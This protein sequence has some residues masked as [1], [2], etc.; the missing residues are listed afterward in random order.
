MGGK[1]NWR[2]SGEGYISSTEGANTYSQ[3]RKLSGVGDYTAAAIASMAFGEPVAVVDGNVYRVLSRHFGIS[4]PIDTTEGKKEFAALAQEL[5][6]A[7]Q[8]SAYN[9]A[10]MDFGATQCVP[11]SPRCE[12]C[13]LL[14]TCVAF[15][16]GR[17]GD[18][19]VKARATKVLTRSLVYIYIRCKGQTA[20]RRRAAGDIWEGLWEPFCASSCLESAVESL[21]RH[22]QQ[23]SWAVRTVAKGVKHQLTHRLLL[24]D[25]HLLETEERPTLPP[26][27]VWMDE[28]D[29]ASHALPRLVE[30][31]FD[32]LSAR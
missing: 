13:P 11:Q 4:T 17:V 20:L 27:Y 24:A 6:P 21:T 2:V 22:L 26:E 32:R 8:A 23:G 16:E 10:I 3:L 5:L 14:G 15:H 29:V 25:F 7:P 18:L 28:A 30:T 19:P 31:L 9:Q 12:R 1:S